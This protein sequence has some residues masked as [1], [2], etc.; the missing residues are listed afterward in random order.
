[1]NSVFRT[2]N[3]QFIV[4]D[5][6]WVA[7]EGT[8][9]AEETIERLAPYI[10]RYAQTLG[11]AV[12]AVGGAQDHLHVLYDL[13]PNRTADEVTAELQK[14]TARY[15][16]DSLAVR[17]FA[18]AEASSIFSVSPHEVSGLREYIEENFQRHKDG[19][20][21]AVYEGVLEEDEGDDEEMPDWLRDVMENRG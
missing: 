16:R 13:A 6:W 9:L 5:L 1:M 8:K 15:L 10:A 19:R 12:L 3:I 21:V 7:E 17:G 4:H 11:V 14:T 2:P 20:L 18:W